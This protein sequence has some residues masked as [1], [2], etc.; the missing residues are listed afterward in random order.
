[1]REFHHPAEVPQMQFVFL[2]VVNC[3]FAERR[4]DAGD[5]HIVSI[6]HILR[7][8]DIVVVNFGDVFAPHAAAN[9]DGIRPGCNAEFNGFLKIGFG[10]LVS[11]KT[12]INHSEFLR[13]CHLVKTMTR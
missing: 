1:M 11:K 8:F 3:A 13:F 10:N 9:F 7:T 2:L 5:A 4:T 12:D 6:Q